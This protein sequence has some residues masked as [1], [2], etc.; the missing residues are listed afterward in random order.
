MTVTSQQSAESIRIG[1]IGTGEITRIMRPAF[2][3]PTQA[4][5]VAVADVNKDAARAKAEALGDAQSFADYRELLAM[6]E[7]VQALTDVGY[8]GPVGF[9]GYKIVGHPPETLARSIK[10]WRGA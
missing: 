6:A 2:T 8:S 3:G 5:V 1:I 4:R 9:Q 10:A 7:F